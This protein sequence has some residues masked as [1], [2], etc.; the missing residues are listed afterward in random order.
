MNIWHEYIDE[1]LGKNDR[2]F[3]FHLVS[4]VTKHQHS[5]YYDVCIRVV[6]D[7]G[8]NIVGKCHLTFITQLFKIIDVKIT[9]ITYPTFTINC[10]LWKS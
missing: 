9:F 4:V 3:P 10:S 5:S 2:K 1:K 7:G 6:T 8:F